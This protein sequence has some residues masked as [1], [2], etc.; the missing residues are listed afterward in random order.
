MRFRSIDG[1]Q[2]FQSEENRPFYL[3]QFALYFQPVADCL[4]FSL[5]ENH[6]HFII[7]VKHSKDLFASVSAISRQFRTNSM[8]VFLNDTLNEQL[9][10]KMV[11]RQVNSFMISYAK[12]INRLFARKGGL[13]QSPFRRSLITNDQYL[14]HAIIYTHANA[15]KHGIVND[16]KEYPFTSYHE[17]LA[18][19]SQ[20]VDADLVL[21]LFGGKEMYI[22][23]HEKQANHFYGNVSV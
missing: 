5:L 17:I 4:A 12:E 15:Q 7:K 9:V 18:G 6:S 2:L 16:F 13:F 11:E 3:R 21:N 8:Q 19:S 10:T 20:N 14:Q 1:L 23:L 22:H